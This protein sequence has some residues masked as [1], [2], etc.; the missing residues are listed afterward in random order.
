MRTTASAKEH[1]VT[2]KSSSLD[3][4]SQWSP[5]PVPVSSLLSSSFPRRWCLCQTGARRPYKAGVG[6]GGGGGC[7]NKQKQRGNPP[8][9]NQEPL[10]HALNRD[11]VPWERLIQSG[12]RQPHMA[13][14]QFR[15]SPPPSFCSH[16]WTQLYQLIDD[17]IQ[18][19]QPCFFVFLISRTH[20]WASINDI[21]SVD[22]Q[23]VPFTP[24]TLHCQC[25]HALRCFSFSKGIKKDASTVQFKKR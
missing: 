3:V 2:K 22:E 6:G 1:N 18:F 24:V 17:T 10:I 23:T 8:K 9:S 21:L 11:W 15:R 25:T 20:Y 4:L 14:Q 12:H 16:L 7:H 13:L 19:L 5:P